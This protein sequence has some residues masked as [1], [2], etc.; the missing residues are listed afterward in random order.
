MPPD[1]PDYNDVDFSDL[2]QCQTFA[3]EQGWGTCEES[4]Q[5]ACQHCSAEI[6]ACA[7]VYS[8]LFVRKCSLG[9][10]DCSPDND[11]YFTGYGAAA[12]LEDALE[13]CMTAADCAPRCP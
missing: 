8:C 7:G 10:S 5:C 9:I 3:D 1:Y 11:P 12:S 13:A 2:M 4:T 6:A